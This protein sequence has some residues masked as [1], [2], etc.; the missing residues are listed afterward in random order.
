[1]L[2]NNTH[3]TQCTTYNDTLHYTTMQYDPIQHNA[4]Q[5]PCQCQLSMPIPMPTP[6][7]AQHTHLFTPNCIRMHTQMA[8]RHAGTS[9]HVSPRRASGASATSKSA[10]SRSAT[11]TCGR[12]VRM[13]AH[14]IRVRAHMCKLNV[15]SDASNS[16][17]TCPRTCTCIHAFTLYNTST[18]CTRV[19]CNYA[20][21]CTLH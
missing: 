13:H 5:C 18:C 3:Y 15:C 14:S 2:Y 11:C 12:L 19:Q 6:T 1:M 21:V 20:L 9:T 16:E 4:Y 8:C 17:C 7:P 10:S